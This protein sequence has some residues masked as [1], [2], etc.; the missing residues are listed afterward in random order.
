MK[1]INIDSSGQFKTRLAPGNYVVDIRRVGT[2]KV[3]GVPE[4]INVE[5]DK[6]IN[7]EISVFEKDITFGLPLGL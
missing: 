7:L 2:E 4:V 3:I 1:A 6:D 5:K